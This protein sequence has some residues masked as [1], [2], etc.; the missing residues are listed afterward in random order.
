MT[1]SIAP[2]TG[3]YGQITESQVAL[4]KP[5][6]PDYFDAAGV[7]LGDDNDMAVLISITARKMHEAGAPLMA[8][9]LV[10]QLANAGGSEFFTATWEQYQTRFTRRGRNA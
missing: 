10:E 6:N 8:C 2:K 4:V 9:Y 7:F 3:Q 1:V 5:G